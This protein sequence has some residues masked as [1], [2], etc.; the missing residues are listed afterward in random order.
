M[1]DGGYRPGEPHEFRIYDPKE[2]LIS[3]LPFVDRVAQQA[4]CAVIGP[5]FEKT[6]LPGSYACQKGKGTHAAAIALQADMRRLTRDAEPLNA[7]KTDI[8]RYFASIERARSGS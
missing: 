4:L 3:A 6:Y 7:L 5:I 8:S 1:R 2:R